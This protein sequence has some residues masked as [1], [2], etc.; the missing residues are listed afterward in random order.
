MIEKVECIDTGDSTG[1]VSLRWG[2]YPWP[3]PAHCPLPTAHHNQ[4]GLTKSSIKIRPTTGENFH[5]ARRNFQKA[6]RIQTNSLGPK[7]FSRSWKSPLDQ[8]KFH[9]LEEFCLIQDDF[10]N[11]NKF[12]WIFNWLENCPNHHLIFIL[13]SRTQYCPWLVC[14]IFNSAFSRIF[15]Y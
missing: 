13:P 1:G 14:C 4:V 7:M 10:N 15:V 9:S 12:T 3:P 5:L 6:F 8:D 2:L 11:S